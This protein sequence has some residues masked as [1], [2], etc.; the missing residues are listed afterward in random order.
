MAAK[1]FHIRMLNANV[2]WNSEMH[3]GSSQHNNTNC[4]KVKTM[5]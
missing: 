1:L 3:V 4:S 2:D 5:Y